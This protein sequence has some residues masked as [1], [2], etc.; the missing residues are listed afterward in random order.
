MV[1]VATN[2]IVKNGADFIGPCLEAVL[3]HVTRSYVALDVASSDGTSAVLFRLAQKYRNLHV[4]HY[5]IRG[6]PLEDLTMVRN[7]LLQCT[8]EQWVWVVDDDEFYPDNEIRA[9]LDELSRE[10]AHIYAFP[11]WLLYD[12][13]RYHTMRS[14]QYA[15]RIFRNVSTMEW[16]GAFGKEMLVYNG[17]TPVLKP[18]P[19]RYI[20]FSFI[21]KNS[22]RKDFNRPY[23]IDGKRNL[24]KLPQDVRREVEKILK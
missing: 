2:T 1:E 17:F 14:R 5:E 24:R 22:W 6:N 16:K 13:E 7:A 9:I 8:P 15:P 19:N 21:K 20:H 4:M 18:M 10:E 12:R 3:P 23:N 11:F